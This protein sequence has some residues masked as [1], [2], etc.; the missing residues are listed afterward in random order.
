[1]ARIGRYGCGQFLFPTIP[2]IT[3][4]ALQIMGHS[5]KQKYPFLEFV[6][7]HFLSQ[8][9]FYATLIVF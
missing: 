1:M 7:T 2:A 4:Q 5:Q 9:N 8:Y 6:M 3:R